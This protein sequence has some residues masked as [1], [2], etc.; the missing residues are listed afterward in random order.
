MAESPCLLSLGAICQNSLFRFLWALGD[1][2]PI[3]LLP[4]ESS[5]RSK[6]IRM[7]VGY[8]VPIAPAEFEPAD[9]ESEIT[10]F[11]ITCFGSAQWAL[12]L[13]RTLA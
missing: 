2:A 13:L 10:K 11:L 12:P 3:L 6:A 1:D 8:I 4:R 9:A 5:G 7:R